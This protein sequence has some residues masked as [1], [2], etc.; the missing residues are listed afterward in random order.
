MIEEIEYIRKTVELATHRLSVVTLDAKLMRAEQSQLCNGRYTAAGC[1]YFSTPQILKIVEEEGEMKERV[2]VR[3]EKC[4][5]VI[6]LNDAR[7]NQIDCYACE[8]KKEGWR[9]YEEEK[10]KKEANWKEFC[11]GTGQEYKKEG[12]RDY[13]AEQ[14]RQCAADFAAAQRD[15]LE[16]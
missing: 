10:E 3:E 6:I 15:Q 1:N 4:G 16:K 12:W 2:M 8:Y 9:D 13:E 11:R 7:G 5:D 14:K